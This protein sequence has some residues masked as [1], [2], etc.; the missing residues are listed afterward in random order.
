MSNLS[1]VTGKPR[2][3]WSVPTKDKYFARSPGLPAEQLT[4]L[5]AAAMRL[6]RSA[7]FV[8]FTVPAVQASPLDAGPNRWLTAKWPMPRKVAGTAAERR[9]KV[10]GNIPGG[11]L[12]R[13]QIVVAVFLLLSSGGGASA[14]CA[15]ARDHYLSAVDGVR[16]YLGRYVQCITTSNGLEDCSSEFR[17]LSNAH[18]EF[19][20]SVEEFRA[21]CP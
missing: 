20:K 15:E 14:E 17:R 4:V 7:A 16:E 8:T 12:V 1:L 3:G 19:E 10:A 9:C 18:T 2:H 5:S 13:C 21:D 11:P 6:P